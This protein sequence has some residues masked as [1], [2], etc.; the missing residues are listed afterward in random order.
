MVFVVY[1]TA[2]DDE[3]KERPRNSN[4]HAYA[5]WVMVGVLASFGLGVVLACLQDVLCPTAADEQF[6]GDDPSFAL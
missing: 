1:N 6:F 3:R 4:P 2:W 5:Y